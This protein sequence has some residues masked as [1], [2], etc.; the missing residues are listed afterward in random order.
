MTTRNALFQI[1]WFLGITAGIVL[2]L[3]GVT[4]GLLSFEDEMLKAMNPGVMS[5]EARGTPLSP[6]ALVARIREQ[7][8]DDRI[9]SL[10]MSRDAADASIHEHRCVASRGG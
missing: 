4:G 1:H 8:P 5:V 6:D 2:A 7:R 3:V 10:A 9:Q